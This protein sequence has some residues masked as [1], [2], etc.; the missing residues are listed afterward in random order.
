MLG[1]NDGV[2]YTTLFGGQCSSGGKPL[3]AVAYNG[4]VARSIPEIPLERSVEVSLSK[5]PHPHRS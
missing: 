5:A 2:T 3:C 1:D 4:K